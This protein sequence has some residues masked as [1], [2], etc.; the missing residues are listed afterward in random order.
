[1]KKLINLFFLFSIIFLV[2]GCGKKQ[3]ELPENASLFYIYTLN[4]EETKVEK[5]QCSTELTDTKEQLNFLLSQLKTVPENTELH[6]TITDEMGLESFSLT[7]GRLTLHFGDG[8]KNLSAT[9]EVLTRAA[10]VRTV[11]QIE[12]VEYVSFMINDTALLNASGTPVGVMTADQFLDNEG[13]EMNA[14]EKANLTLYFATEDGKHLK[15]YSKTQVYNSNISLEKLVVEQIVAGPEGENM[16]NPT[17]NPDT[18]VLSV[19]V[20][21]RV[22]YV[23][24]SKEFLTQTYDV[25]AEATVYSLVNSLVELTDINKVQIA[26]DG[27]TTQVFRETI[28][29]STVFERNLE[30]ME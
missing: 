9:S 8:Y 30:I 21:D 20:K 7:D 18:K 1:M 29:L 11:C 24:L 25:S 23:N 19:T 15:A 4:K 17:I 16:G 28:P 13:G 27:E 3:E 14:Y 5:Y 26:V 6:Q 22:C 2:G 12:G 10:I